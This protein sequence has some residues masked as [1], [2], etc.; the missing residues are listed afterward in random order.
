MSLS[1]TLT[2]IAL[3]WLV[4]VITPG[5]NFFITAQVAVC[6]TRRAAL[7]VVLGLGTGTLVWGLCGLWGIRLLFQSAPWL[8]AGLK[9]AGGAYLIYL[10]LR[11][12]IKKPSPSPEGQAPECPS[13]TSA[14]RI[15]T[16]LLTS[17]SNPKAAAFVTSL[18]ASAFPKDIPLS[19]GLLGVMLMVLISSS[20]YGLVAV[21]FS[22]R[23]F[24]RLYRLWRRGIER[25]AAA[26]FVGFGLKL[27][28]GR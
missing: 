9:V 13:G 25:F 22:H 19:T 7:F 5:P 15:R 8:Y 6:S 17:L 18:F 27:A 10:G 28:V 24:Q 11:L 26:V 14:G 3:I 1:L 20:W 4:A 2:S 21:A 16:G 23:R 12:W